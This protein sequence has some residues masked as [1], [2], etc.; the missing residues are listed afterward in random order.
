MGNFDFSNAELPRLLPLENSYAE[1]EVEADLKRL[2]LDLFREHLAAKTFDTNVLGAAHLGSFDL[3]RRAVN[4]DGLVLMQGDREEA[5]TRYLYRAWKSGNLQGRGLHFLRT[6]L[7]M[8]F[9][10]VT[11]VVQLWHEKESPYPKGVVEALRPKTW[12]LHQ[13]NEPGLKIDGTWKVNGFVEGATPE[14]GQRNTEMSGLFLTSRIRISLDAGADSRP[15][16]AVRK[17]IRSVIPARLVPEFIYWIRFVAFLK[18]SWEYSMC[19][20]ITG[21]APSPRCGL[22]V[23]DKT[24]GRWKVGLDGNYTKIN[25][26]A[27][28]DGSWRVGERTGRKVTA[29]IRACSAFGEI[30]GSISGAATAW[31]VETIPVEPPLKFAPAPVPAK[32]WRYPMKINADWKIGGGPLIGRLSIN[33]GVKLRLRKMY[34]CERIG[35]FRIVPENPSPIPL[36]RPKARLSINGNGWKVNGRRTPNFEIGIANV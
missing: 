32:L 27:K 3:V 29:V 16:A 1:N 24:P 10:N 13:I 36:P 21:S 5:A 9:P 30:Q 17:I 14:R 22:R 26:G 19:A 6:Y 33:S 23:T 18:Y 25:A 35:S 28:I 2:F 4:A 8:L 20:T 7:Q 12:W 11:D 31:G 15:S 34:R